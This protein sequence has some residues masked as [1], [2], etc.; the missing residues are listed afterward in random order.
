MNRTTPVIPAEDIA[1]QKEYCAELRALNAQRPAPPKAWVDTYGC[2]QNEADSELLRGML[3]EMGTAE[4]L[5]ERKGIYYRL[6]TLQNEQ[7]RKV[8]E[9]R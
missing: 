8:M 9:G 2:Q 3:A 1:K 7:L 4:E 5:M 6:W